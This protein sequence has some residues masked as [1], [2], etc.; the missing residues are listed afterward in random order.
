MEVIEMKVLII[1]YPNIFEKKKNKNNA[2]LHL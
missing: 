1:F 2:I